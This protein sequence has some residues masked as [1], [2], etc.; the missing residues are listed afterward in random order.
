M[1]HAIDAGSAAATG[2]EKTAVEGLRP[3]PATVQHAMAASDTNPN[4]Q[5]RCRP[6]GHDWHNAAKNPNPPI[7]RECARRNLPLPR[8]RSSAPGWLRLSDCPRGR[9]HHYENLDSINNDR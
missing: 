7:R 6:T 9:L 4:T 2:H 3:S 5:A 1:H 8:M